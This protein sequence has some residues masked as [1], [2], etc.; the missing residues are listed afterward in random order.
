[1]YFKLKLRIKNYLKENDQTNMFN[2]KVLLRT[3]MD[4]QMIGISQLDRDEH[5]QSV[6]IISPMDKFRNDRNVITDAYQ[7][8]ILPK[9]F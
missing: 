1:M 7:N 3:D 2:N 8:T 6:D 5:F 9:K 4:Q